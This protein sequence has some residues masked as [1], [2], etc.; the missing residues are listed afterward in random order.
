MLFRS[1]FDSIKYLEYYREADF[2]RLLVKAEDEKNLSSY[3]YPIKNNP[4]AKVKWG[5]Q[6][7]THGFVSPIFIREPGLA[8]TRWRPW[9]AWG[10]AR[11]AAL[12]REN[13]TY[14]ALLFGFL[15]SG[16]VPENVK[17]ALAAA[18][19]TGYP[20]FDRGSKVESLQFMREPLDEND[21]RYWDAGDEF[22]T[23][24]TL[25]S[26]LAGKGKLGLQK[27]GGRALEESKE[28]GTSARNVIVKELEQFK[29]D[30][31]PVVG[32]AVVKQLVLALQKWLNFRGSKTNGEDK[33][34]WADLHDRAGKF[35]LV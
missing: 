22:S 10:G 26:Y 16:D 33:K 2:S 6:R 9:Q 21:N 11:S 30:I 24:L 32:G 14:D 31:A 35:N 15:G 8:S 27:Q 3:Y 28:A 17:E 18:G 13:A 25:R 5:E 1:P 19:W 23:I 12:E 7:D 20:L 4:A 29:K 34:L